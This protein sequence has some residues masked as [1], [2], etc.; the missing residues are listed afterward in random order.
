ML[1]SIHGIFVLGG[2]DYISGMVTLGE[3]AIMI[4]RQKCRVGWSYIALVL[5]HY[6]GWSYSV[7]ERSALESGFPN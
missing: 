2:A 7:D 5:L 6:V 4:T 1:V 3:Y